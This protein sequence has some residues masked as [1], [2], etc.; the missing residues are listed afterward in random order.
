VQSR[1]R[2]AYRGVYE[3]QRTARL[4]ALLAVLVSIGVS[5][6]CGPQNYKSSADPNAVRAAL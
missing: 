5:I 6:F 3:M 4:L 2:E 1:K